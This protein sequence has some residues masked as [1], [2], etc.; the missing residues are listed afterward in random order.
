MIMMM[1]SGGGLR[2]SLFGIA[3]RYGP[4]G[5]GFEPGEVKEFYLLNSRSDRL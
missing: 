5:S 3:N 1:I 2:D 4:G